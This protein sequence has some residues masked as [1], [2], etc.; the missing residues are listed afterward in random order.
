MKVIG[1]TLRSS[2]ISVC[3]PNFS[4][5]RYCC[6]NTSLEITIQ[7]KIESLL[8]I[9]ILHKP[10]MQERQKIQVQSPPSLRR[11]WR[12]NGNPFPELQK[13]AD[14][15]QYK[16]R[17]SPLREHWKPNT[18]RN[19]CS[20]TK[21]HGASIYETNEADS[22]TGAAENWEASWLRHRRSV[23]STEALRGERA[24]ERTPRGPG[25]ATEI[26]DWL[27]GITKSIPTQ[28]ETNSIT[29]SNIA[30]RAARAAGR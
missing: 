10:A 14:G 30:A 24:E 28:V 8:S 23:T 11:S 15:K 20:V 17:C 12:E 7:I 18:P 6:E 4:P 5:S 21:H 19:Y 1:D 26:C 25:R 9:N 2:N 22:A 3:P 16:Y 13:I 29:R 27:E